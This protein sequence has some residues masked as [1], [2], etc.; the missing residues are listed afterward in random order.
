[1]V[2]R[3][4][5]RWRPAVLG[6]LLTATATFVG[7]VLLGQSVVSG[8]S[9]RQRQCHTL[10][11]LVAL[12]LD[13]DVEC[14][15]SH[16]SDLD[17]DGVDDRVIAYYRRRSVDAFELR[18]RFSPGRGDLSD[19]RLDETPRPL[20]PAFEAVVDLDGNGR[21]EVLV[22][23]AFGTNTHSV[24]AFTVEGG[25]LVPVLERGSAGRD[26]PLEFALGGALAHSDGYS[27]EDVNGDTKPE[28]V[29]TSSSGDWDREG[30]WE[31]RR[32]EYRWVSPR[33]VEL[34]RMRSGTVAVDWQYTAERLFDSGA[35]G[36]SPATASPLPLRDPATS[37]LEAATGLLDAWQKGDRTQ[38]AAFAGVGEVSGADVLGSLFDSGI[39]PTPATVERCDDGPFG[40]RRGLLCPITVGSSPEPVI[41]FEVDKSTIGPWFGVVAVSRPGDAEPGE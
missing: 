7:L 38:A 36:A 18:L 21:P 41:V 6:W 17:L 10:E 39:D 28:L 11:D 33:T 14:A 32:K 20:E 31:W 22:V 35:C 26:T 24:A 12:G 37:P 34:V 1:M 3:R 30:E 27:C 29:L 5:I 25:R 23:K 4:S 19:V 2:D 9:Q 13:R 8:V 15:T 16:V 40:A